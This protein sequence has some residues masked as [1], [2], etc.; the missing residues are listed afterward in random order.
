MDDLATTERSRWELW[1]EVRHGRVSREAFERV[2]E[3]EVAFLR[4][5]ADEP[6]HRIH[7]R[8]RGET[9]RWYPVAARLLHQ[10]VL[11]PEPPEF[12]TELALPFT[13]PAIRDADDPWAEACRL[14]P[15]KFASPAGG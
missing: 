7:V 13:F 3:D 8:W 15:E 12:V 2:L 6:G 10:L 14:C 4:G 9:A 5:D 1:A 11:A